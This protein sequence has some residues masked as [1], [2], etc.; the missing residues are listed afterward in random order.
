V[1]WPRKELGDTEDA[2]PGKPR[3]V[4]TAGVHQ[5]IPDPHMQIPPLAK[6]DEAYPLE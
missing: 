5:G 3:V 4:E 2:S 6:P 1:A